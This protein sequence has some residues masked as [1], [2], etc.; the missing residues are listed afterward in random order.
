MQI[1]RHVGRYVP[2]LVWEDLADKQLI[3]VQVVGFHMALVLWI[4][5][6][7]LGI[8]ALACRKH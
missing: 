4:Q 2:R 3:V 1:V 8:A 5:L 7:R 6:M